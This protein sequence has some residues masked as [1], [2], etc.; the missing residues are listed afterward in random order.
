MKGYGICARVLRG[1]SSGRRGFGL[2]GLSII[3][4]V[5]VVAIVVAMQL[6]EAPEARYRAKRSEYSTPGGTFR[7]FVAARQKYVKRT[8]PFKEMIAC[9][10]ED[11][12]IWFRE[13]QKYI[14]TDSE[15]GFVAQAIGAESEKRHL[16]LKALLKEAP[17]SPDTEITKEFQVGDKAVVF[18]QE[19]DKEPEAVRLVKEGQNWKILEWF[20]QRWGSRTRKWLGHKSSDDSTAKEMDWYWGLSQA[21]QAQ[22]VRDFYEAVGAPPP[23]LPA[24]GMSEADLAYA[25]RR[26]S[27]SLKEYIYCAQ[28]FLSNPEREQDVLEYFGADDYQWFSRYWEEICLLQGIDPP[29]TTAAL[30]EVIEFGP[31]TYGADVGEIHVAGPR[32]LV[33]VKEIRNEGEKERDYKV[34]MELEG[35]DWKLQTLFFGRDLHWM[36]NI[37]KAKEARG[38]ALDSDELDYLQHGQGRF[39]E[40]MTEF[41]KSV[42]APLE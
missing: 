29:T 12:A 41:Y 25:E 35:N 5:I 9:M 42:G 7:A 37:L 3:I 33:E 1:R 32:A 40:R 20:D 10:T 17:E 18:Y 16:A 19:P 13:N 8:D 26:V 36:P 38:E 39:K 24:S 27:I 23:D 34:C 2:K 4:I 22:E 21:D 6:Q 15:Y 11:D 28:S 14:A 30:K 31:Q